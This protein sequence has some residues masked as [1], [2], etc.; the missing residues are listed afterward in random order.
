MAATLRLRSVPAVPT[1]TEWRIRD[2]L[3]RDF[4]VRLLS[5]DY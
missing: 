2:W 3:P 4:S 5:N 1:A